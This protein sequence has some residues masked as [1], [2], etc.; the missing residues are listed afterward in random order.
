MGII[1]IMERG[2]DDLREYKKALKM[3]KQGIETICE[4]SEEMEDQYSER[5]DYG[6]RYGSRGG[7][8]S[9]GYSRRDD[10]DEMDERRYRDSRG[11]YM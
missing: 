6:E 4:L 7:Y 8:R 11:H 5:A 9:R 2:G 10:W 1:H 3:A